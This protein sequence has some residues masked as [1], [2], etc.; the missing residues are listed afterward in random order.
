MTG[1]EL[2]V[3]LRDAASDLQNVQARY[4]G[5]KGQLASLE[6]VEWIRVN[7]VTLANTAKENH[8]AGKHINTYIEELRE[9][10]YP[11]PFAEWNGRIYHTGELIIG[12]FEEHAPGL[13]K[14]LQ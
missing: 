4:D 13:Y 5:L 6:S 11:L 9:A 10:R 7:G 1:P 2:E 12:R 3:R 14:D 8:A